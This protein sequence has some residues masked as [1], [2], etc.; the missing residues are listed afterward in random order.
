MPPIRPAAFAFLIALLAAPASAQDAP[1]PR[2]DD[3]IKALVLEAIRENPGIIEEAVQL[4]REQEEERQLLAAR[5]V[6][7]DRAAME[8]NAPVIANV[9][10][11]V[12]VVEFL[13]YNC[14]Y[15]KRALEEVD[16]L[17]AAD[18]NVRLVV[19]EWPILGP[20]SVVAARAALAAREQGQYEEMHEALMA[21]DR[22]DESSVMGAAAAIGLDVEKLAADMASPTIDAHFQRSNE[23][24]LGLG[25]SGTPSFVVGD[26]LVPGVA[27]ADAMRDLVE[28]ARAAAGGN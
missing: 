12:T 4:L 22:A 3:E 21:L 7:E 18:P 17:V 26:E 19:R 6:L 23:L 20:D 13:D 8:E 28:R 14:P 11:D 5:A 1:V 9:E 15:C 27:P 2:T 10:G 25:F 16:A 24:A